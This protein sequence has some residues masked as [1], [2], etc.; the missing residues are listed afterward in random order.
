MTSALLCCFAHAFG[1]LVRSTRPIRCCATAFHVCSQAIRYDGTH[2][3]YACNNSANFQRNY[4]RVAL[5]QDPSCALEFAKLAVQSELFLEEMYQQETG[6][7]PRLLSK[8]FGY[9]LKINDID[10]VRIMQ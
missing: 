10:R 5:H 1:A 6:W 7:K 2:T 3:R 9:A 4:G 8:T